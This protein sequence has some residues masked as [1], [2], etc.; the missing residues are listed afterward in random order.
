M[1]NNVDGTSAEMK[2]AKHN[3]D[4][5]RRQNGGGAGGVGCPPNYGASLCQ[6]VRY[7]HRILFCK[8]TKQRGKQ[9]Y[10]VTS[11]GKICGK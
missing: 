5:N 4:L 6:A 11:I 2:S 7:S 8:T 9:R 10:V 3:N 1:G